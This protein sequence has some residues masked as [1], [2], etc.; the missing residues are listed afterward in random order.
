[1]SHEIRTPINTIIGLNEMILRE[2]ISDEVAED[3][4]NVRSAGKMLLHLINDILD[5]TKLDSGQMQLSPVN[6]RPG[7][8]LS[9]LVGMLW[10]RAKEKGLGFHVNV[11]PELPSELIGDEVRIYQILINVVNNAIKYTKEGDVSLSIDCG[12]REG[13]TL[14]VVYTV[15]DTGVGI[16]KENI[17]HLFTAF[18]RVDET[19]NR[20]IEGTGLGLSIVKQLVELMH[21]TITVNSIYTKGSTFIIEIPQQVASEE[22]IH[23]ISLEKR[24]RAGYRKTYQ[25]KFEAPEA[26]VLVVDDNVSNLLVVTKLLRE[27]K[28]QVETAGSGAEALKKT[29]AEHYHVIFMDHL[30]PEM[31]GL[32]CRRQIRNQMGGKCRESRIVALTANAGSD[33]RALYEKEGFDGYLVKPVAGEELERELC[34]LLPHDLLYMTGSEEEL[35]EDTVSWMHADQSRRGIVITTDSVADLPRELTEAYGI[36]VIPHM[37]VTDEGTFMDGLEIETDGLLGYMQDPT[38]KVVTKSP[39]VAEYERFFAEQLSRANNVI[40]VAITSSVENSGCQAAMEAADAFDN[41]TV[42]ESGHLSSGEGLMA[43]EACRLAAAG[44]TVQEIRQALD[45]L[46]SRI[47]TSFVVSD[48]EFLTRAGQVS[49]RSLR[50]TR[51]FMASPV[52]VLRHGRIH[53]GAVLLGAREESWKRYIRKTLSHGKI[54]DE[55]LFI[56]HVGLT[57]WELEQIKAMVHERVQ[58]RKVYCVK[59]SPAISVNCGPGTFGLLFKYQA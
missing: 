40:H 8:M 44:K 6:Y 29:L 38:R 18:R 21:G 14:H 15:T 35:Y 48:L 5:M 7:D 47:N 52:L 28:V 3:A 33:S 54:D 30:M 32:E 27:T 57:T 31:D 11:S 10:L 49:Q 20:H 24:Q 34:R 43:L 46:R 25:K 37:V 36:G 26:K 58:F 41:V 42:I 22:K 19:E 4:S 16:K 13:S 23:E 39:G 59:A 12:K 53:T 45:G 9:E 55:I 56:T 17:P 51:A 2:D 50:I 1:M